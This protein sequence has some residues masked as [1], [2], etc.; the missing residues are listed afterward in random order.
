MVH[1]RP[2][3]FTSE[4]AVLEAAV[5]AVEDT[6]RRVVAE[7]LGVAPAD[8]TSEVS[9]VD[10]LAADSLDLIDIALAVEAE[11]GVGVP[12]RFFD[13]GRTWGELVAAVAAL[14]RRRAR[15][16]RTGGRGA[17]LLVRAAL[18]G[19]DGGTPQTFER[20]LW[21]TPY[22]AET[23]VADVA[24]AGPGARLELSVPRGTT[25]IALVWL[26]H[27]LAGVLAR[28][29]RVRLRRG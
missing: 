20:A 15:F 16:G 14:P 21:L 23:L 2:T 10:D 4:A 24:H 11:L 13:Q 29:V 18:H 27:Q 8:L 28:G 3:R 19:T 25:E 7:R 26:R 6:L 17:P 1:S 22:G 9:L 12:R 5:P